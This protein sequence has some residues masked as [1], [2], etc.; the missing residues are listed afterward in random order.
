MLDG[1]LVFVDIDTQ[2]DFMEPTGAL[3]VPGAIEIVE[4]LS[5]LSAFAREHGIPILATACAH[6]L[7][8]RDPEPFPPHCLI[9]TP[10]QQRIAAT[11]LEDGEVVDLGTSASLEEPPPIH[12]T[13]HKNRYDL[14]T[15]PAA[16]RIVARYGRD[17][18]TFVVYGVA[19]D[20]CVKAAVLGLLERGHKVAVVVDAIRAVDPRVE[21]E[22]L[23]EFVRRGAYLVRTQT[24][25]T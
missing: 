17:R 8:E 3:Y 9:G 1:P 25:C 22:I 4:N 6:T 2:R 23:T 14:F 5:R 13:I 16:D 20:Y 18:P 10:G 21:P 15:H 24:V 11:A 7:D 19:T 12:L